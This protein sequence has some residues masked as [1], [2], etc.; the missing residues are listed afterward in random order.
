M[1]I[2]GE[3]SGDLHGASVMK[4][5]SLLDSSI[6]FFGIGG[7]KMIA[8]GMKAKYHI[9]QMAF[10]G[11][12]EVI[13][14]LPFINKVKSDLLQLAEKE[15]IETIILI[16]Y[17]GFNLNIAHKFH[18]R[19]KKLIYFISPQVWAW[20]KGRIEKIKIMIKKMLV[21][22]PFEEKIYKEAGVD[23]VYVGHP[24]VE[25]AENYNFLSKAELYSKFELDNEKD[26]LLLLPGS[27]KQEIKRIFGESLEAAKQ[28]A[29]EFDL[30][31]VVA[32][33]ENINENI[34]T[35][36]SYASGYKIVKG[37]TYDLFK[38]AKFG[39]IK[40]GTSTLEAAYFQLPFVVVYVTN[41]I[42]YLIGKLLAK[43]KNIAMA[44]IILGKTAVPELIQ[45]GAC[46]ENIYNTSRVY[47]SSK[48]SLDEMKRALSEIKQKLGSSG[49]SKRAAEIIFKTMNEAY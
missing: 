43:V 34:F 25:H 14:H 2:A 47:L 13:R 15:R 22:F 27:R 8:S 42:T 7:D 38:L 30:Q 10:L 12:I 6:E 24:L 49:A 35:D 33:A 28:L 23:A 44:N 48:E 29:K 17:P 45:N 32:C 36:I 4:E 1:I 21:I 11:F 16:D 5:L 41:P 37:F 18:S 20:G 9:K 3:A 40:S 26:I 39:I 46:K 19:G 31:I